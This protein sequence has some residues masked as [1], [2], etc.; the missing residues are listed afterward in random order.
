MTGRSSGSSYQNQL[1][2][3]GDGDY[4]VQ[5]AS[6]LV[7]STNPNDKFLGA[8]V[9]VLDFTA[10]IGQSVAASFLTEGLCSL[11][12]GNQSTLRLMSESATG[13]VSSL[14]CSNKQIGHQ[15]PTPKSFQGLL[16]PFSVP[17]N[18]SVANL[19]LSYLVLQ[20]GFVKADAVFGNN[21]TL[22]KL[23]QTFVEGLIPLSSAVPVTLAIA[24]RFHTEQCSQDRG[25]CGVVSDVFTGY[26]E[27]VQAFIEGSG[28][29]S[30]T[31][32]ASAWTAGLATV[33][34]ALLF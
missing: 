10:S 5:I 4:V 11:A 31:S 13:S 1:F 17:A 7:S 28:S 9:Q 16:I 22:G 8:A 25:S 21:A 29:G 33:C 14:A 26:C 18:A 23:N 30:G 12:S 20:G 15:N 27:D 34:L 19:K 2:T 3:L 6:N 32:S 24:Q